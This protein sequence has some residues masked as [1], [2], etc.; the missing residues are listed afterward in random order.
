M[1]LLG[2]GG[3]APKDVSM[4]ERWA[5]TSSPAGPDGTRTATAPPPP[6]PPPRASRKTSAVHQFGLMSPPDSEGYHAIGSAFGRA[7][8]EAGRAGP[9]GPVG[10]LADADADATRRK[11]QGRARQAGTRRCGQSARE[12]PGDQSQ[13][14][15]G[16]GEGIANGN[17]IAN[18]TAPA[19][20]PS[21]SP[22]PPPGQR[23]TAYREKNR[24]AAAKCRAKKKTQNDSLLERD[25][26][27][28]HLNRALKRDLMHLRNVLAELKGHTLLHDPEVCRCRGIHE[29]SRRQAGLVA[30]GV[31]PGYA[32]AGGADAVD[33][34]ANATAPPVEAVRASVPVSPVA[35]RRRAPRP[36]AQARDFAGGE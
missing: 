17:G 2:D 13:M 30:R 1:Q 24:V 29:Y 35:P 10:P 28:S 11:R 25:R 26:R 36:A 5:A 7:E 9:V 18:G 33:A 15:G 21:A 23:Q 22:P 3:L 14:G 20:A 8:G 6:P 4:S 16:G 32:A 27:E 31:A 12:G 19:P 34:N